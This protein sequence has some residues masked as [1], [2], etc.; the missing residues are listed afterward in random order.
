MLET[1]VPAVNSA[2]QRAR[3][4]MKEHL[5][6]RRDEW[7][8]NT[9]ATAA[10]RELLDRFVEYCESPDPI[11]LKRLLSEDARFSMPPQPG[12]WEGRDEVVQC[13]I[14]GGFGSESFGSLRCVV[15]RANRQPAVACSRAPGDDGYSPLAID[16]L[17][18]VD[19]AVAD[20]VTFDGSVFSWFGLPETL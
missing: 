11:A 16:V 3:A 15:T 4:A 13:W 10:E 8:S 9:A 2:L 14:D 12:I 6:E 1:S 17:R 5:P 7:P 20:I 18:I 19:G